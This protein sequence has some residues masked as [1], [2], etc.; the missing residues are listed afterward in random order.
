MRPLTVITGIVLGSCF[1][2]TVGLAAVL[3]IFLVLGDDYPRLQYEFRPLTQSL[4]IFT[5]MTAIAALSFYWLVVEHRWRFAAQA[6]LWLAVV[7]T[8]Y[9]FWP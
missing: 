9:F 2:I 5:A 4:A 8:G 6:A 1:S 3:V 7:A